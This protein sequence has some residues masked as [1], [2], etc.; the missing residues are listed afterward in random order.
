MR[1]VHLKEQSKAKYL[2]FISIAQR[3]L[4]RKEK[5]CQGQSL[6]DLDLCQKLMSSFVHPVWHFYLCMQFFGKQLTDIQLNKKTNK[7]KTFVWVAY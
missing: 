2:S 6:C 4:K 5:L 3:T 1:R 7:Q